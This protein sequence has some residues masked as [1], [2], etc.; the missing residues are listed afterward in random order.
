MTEVNAVRN[1]S[2][3]SIEE[4]PVGA[5][6]LGALVGMIASG[7]ISGKIGKQVFEHMLTDEATPLAIVEKYGLL[8]IDDEASLLRLARE[9]IAAHPGPA[10]EVRAGKEKT[11]AF[12]V[13]QA[14]KASQ[15]RAHPERV[16]DALRA[17]LSEGP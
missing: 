7:G 12:L 14:M 11:F 1:K 17:A 3:Q 4:F 13:G 6:R 9:V 15:G 16:Q 2:G 5:D 10:A 8:P